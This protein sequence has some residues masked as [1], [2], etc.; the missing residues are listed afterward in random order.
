M[1]D[2]EFMHILTIHVHV[3]VHHVG[4]CRYL[5]KKD[6]RAAP[7]LAEMICC[8]GESREAIPALYGT[9]DAAAVFGILLIHWL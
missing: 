7:E 9:V 6:T 4:I 5:L 8:T 2:T 3:R 1:C